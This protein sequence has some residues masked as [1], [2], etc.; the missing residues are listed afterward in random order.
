M[1]AIFQYFNTKRAKSKGKSVFYGCIL[2]HFFISNIKK[3]FQKVSF[4]IVALILRG[5]ISTNGFC[6][7]AYSNP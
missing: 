1:D 4:L 7:D 6:K 3:G 5:Y 2:Y